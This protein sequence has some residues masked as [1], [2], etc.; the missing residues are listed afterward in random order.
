MRQARIRKCGDGNTERHACNKRCGTCGIQR[1]TAYRGDCKEG[2]SGGK[3]MFLF[4]CSSFA[5]LSGSLMNTSLGKL[6]AVGERLVA[7]G[8]K[9]F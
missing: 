8:E 5:S 1:T 6:Q 3:H 4:M 7:G 9:E 2:G